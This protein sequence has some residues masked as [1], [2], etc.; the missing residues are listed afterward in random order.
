MENLKESRSEYTANLELSKASNSNKE[1]SDAKAK[2][3]KVSAMARQTLNKLKSSKPVKKKTNLFGFFKM[4]EDVE[5]SLQSML[6]DKLTLALKAKGLT[7][8]IVDTDDTTKTDQNSIDTLDKDTL[9]NLRETARHLGS[10]EGVF[11]TSERVFCAEFKTKEQA[12]AFAKEAAELER[13]SIV[14]IQPKNDE[15]SQIVPQQGNTDFESDPVR[16]GKSFFIVHVFLDSLDFLPNIQE[17]TLSEALTNQHQD[18]AMQCGSD[19]ENEVKGSSKYSKL[20][21]IAAAHIYHAVEDPQ[22]KELAKQ[23]YNKHKSDLYVNH[24]QVVRPLESFNSTITERI[25]NDLSHAG[26]GAYKN[27]SGETIALRR[28]GVLVAKKTK[29]PSHQAIVGHKIDEDFDDEELSESLRKV[30]TTRQGA[31]KNHLSEI[32]RLNKVHDDREENGDSNESLSKIIQKHR[33][34][35]NSLRNFHDDAES[36][37]ADAWAR[38]KGWRA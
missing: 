32:D 11:D 16:F 22:E 3:D 28:N 31:I 4:N 20:K 13:V 8:P 5:T 1:E 36:K 35:V 2:S 10:D 25:V 7:S 12:N 38:S 27:S 14:M 33:E 30:Y 29:D 18:R 21:A 26:G 6:V 37:S 34:A 19:A 9:L 24:N 17:S 15:S 23:I